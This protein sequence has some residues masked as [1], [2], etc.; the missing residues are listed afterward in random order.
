MKLIESFFWGI[1]AALGA[2]IAQ[3]FV[4]IGISI[5]SGP[6]AV[7]SFTQLFIQPYFIIIAACIEEFLK[8]IFISKHIKTISSKRSCFINSLFIG[9]GFFGVEFAFFS[10]SESQLPH[11]Q[12]LAEIAVVHTGTA[13][14][15]GY[16]VAMKNFK[17]LSTFLPALLLATFFHLTYNLLAIERAPIENYAIFMLLGLLITF[18]L[19]NFFRFGKGLA[20][21]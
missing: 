13:G 16:F 21:Y 5:Y 6:A 1:V 3:L 9:L 15:I 20:Q 17:K 10:A 4:F 8:Y 18:N 11:A 14:I 2:L 19:A 12:F 7:I